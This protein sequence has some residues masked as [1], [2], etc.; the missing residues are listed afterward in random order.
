VTPGRKGGALALLTPPV[1]SLYKPL[2]I[3]QGGLEESPQ[4]HYGEAKGQKGRREHVEQGEEGQGYTVV[5]PGPESKKAKMKG[6]GR[7]NSQ[8]TS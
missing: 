7:Q 5:H 6:H 1:H 8:H 4:K 2:Q 3:P